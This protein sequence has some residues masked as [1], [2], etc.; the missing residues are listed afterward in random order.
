M[1]WGSEA[2]GKIVF[3][4]M[5][6]NHRFDFSLCH[7]MGG[8]RHRGSYRNYMEFAMFVRLCGAGGRC[9]RRVAVQIL[10]AR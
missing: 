8:R 4:K 10:H 5:V 9:S 2:L 6:A 3:I 1:T 7:R